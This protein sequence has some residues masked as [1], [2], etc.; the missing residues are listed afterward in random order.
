MHSFVLIGMP[1]S[2]KTE[3][4]RM[5]AEALGLSFADLDK[6][7][8]R[9]A[10]RSPR[11]IITE[12]GEAAFRKIETEALAACAGVSDIPRIDTAGAERPGLVL[13]T[14]G[15]IVTAPENLALLRRIGP[16]V[17]I[18]R[19]LDAIADAVSYSHDRPLLQDRASLDALWEARGALYAAWADALFDNKG[20]AA[21]AAAGLT[22]LLR[23]L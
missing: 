23:T 9:R 22:S 1:G 11:A 10:G 6:E 5:A 8:E 15:G 13:S 17:W 21:H 16:I 4:G 12:D 3:L 18:R 14:G 19:E 20:K 7:I 2:G